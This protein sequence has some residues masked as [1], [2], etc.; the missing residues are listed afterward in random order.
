M[1]GKVCRGAGGGGTVRTNL[2]GGQLL[3][4]L[5]CVDLQSVPLISTLEVA[6]K[7]LGGWGVGGGGRVAHWL[8]LDI[9][10]YIHTYVYIHYHGGHLCNN[11]GHLCNNEGRLLVQYEGR[12]LVQ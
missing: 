5:L 4:Q 3:L 2:Y 8:Q 9:H 12:S 11:G 6:L 10:T 7:L 1:R